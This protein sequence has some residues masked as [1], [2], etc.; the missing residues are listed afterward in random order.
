MEK[1]SILSVIANQQKLGSVISKGDSLGFR[2]DDSWRDFRK[3]F[4]LSLSMPLVTREHPQKLIEPYLWGLLPDNQVTLD[5]WGKH[6]HVSPRNVFRLLEH[7]GED[8]AGAIQFIAEE[9]ENE[10]IGQTYTEQVEW[11]NEGQLA[12]RVRLLVESNGTPRIASDEG[13]FSLA[14]AQ[15]K[16]A[17]Y[18]NPV[19]GKWGVPKGMTPTTHILKPSSEKFQGSAE[20]EHFCLRLVA[21]LGIKSAESSVKTCGGIPVI[22]VKRYDRVFVGS[23]FLRV[24][25][26]D[27]C[28]ALGIHP[29][30]K[31]QNDGGPSVKDVAEA[32]WNFSSNAREDIKTFADAI[33]FNF[34][35][36]GTDAH[37]KNYSLL[38]A[39]KNQIR[40]AP[41]YDVASA[42]P[43][44]QDVPLQKA[45]MAMKIGSK[46][47]FERIEARH[48]EDCAKTLR[49]P[50]DHFLKRMKWM[51]GEIVEILPK[52][53]ADL[54]AEG[55]T[56]KVIGTLAEKITQR[57]QEILNR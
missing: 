38:I 19:S 46:Y 3:A 16:T 48:W 36:L 45:K 54:N 51:A 11:L 15:P 50:A 56:H 28:Q 25:Q 23:K 29:S 35:I 37:A 30:L 32:L 6:F 47:L 44:P 24:H 57:A 40:L 21:R 22:V 43:Y 33:L 31:Y 2:Y 26:E 53:A 1:T 52:T 34:I 20:N 49:L 4:P 9:R 42:L 5:Q 8:C 17:L 39:E 41:L 27:M 18:I 10:L 55:L 14:G 13:Q 7:V 12:E